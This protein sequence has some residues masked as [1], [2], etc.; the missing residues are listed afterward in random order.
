MSCK[1]ILLTFCFDTKS[2][3]RIEPNDFMLTSL[4]RV[5][6]SVNSF[7]DKCNVVIETLFLVCLNILELTH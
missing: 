7:W 5:F 6:L 4:F 3:W 1:N 2:I